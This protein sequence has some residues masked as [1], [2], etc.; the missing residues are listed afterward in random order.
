[1]SQTSSRRLTTEHSLTGEKLSLLAV[2]A[3][4]ED[5]SFGPAGTLAKYVNEGVR[6]TLATATNASHSGLAYFNSWNTS[7]APDARDRLCSCRTSGIRRTCF[8]YHP[9]EFRY[10]DTERLEGRLVALIRQVRPQVIITLGPEGT[11]GDTDHILIKEATMAA[12]KSAGNPSKFP[13]HFVEGLGAFSPQKLYL[14]VIPSSLAAH[15][16]GPGLASVQDDQITATLDVSP[17]CD[18]ARNALLCQRRRSLGITHGPLA[19]QGG[20]WNNEYYTLVESHLNRRT[21]R[22]RDLF[23]GLR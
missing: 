14:S 22:E 21:R 1:M 4:V 19:T 20:P 23:A 15:W 2:F 17:Y 6:V 5:E 18:A 9:D 10:V 7:L 12:F 3:H 16:G 13:E 8:D 11:S